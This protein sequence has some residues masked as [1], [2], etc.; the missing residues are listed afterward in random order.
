[1]RRIRIG[2]IG[3]QNRGVRAHAAIPKALQAAG[4]A[5]NA[6]VEPVWLPTAH[7]AEGTEAKLSGLDGLW[8]VPNSPY[9]STQGALQ[10]IRH[11]RER[12]RPFLGTCGGFQHTL[13]EYA[14]HVIGMEYADHCETNPAAAVPLLHR[15]ACSLVGVRGTIRI[16]PGSRAREMYGSESVIEEYHCNYGLNE[17]YR[18]R[19]ADGKLRV[20]GEDEAGN[21]RI[22]EL[23]GHPFFVATLFQP[24]LSAL[25]AA[26]PHPIVLEFVRAA[27]LAESA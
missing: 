9:E 2:L 8:C 21:V 14:R 26:I 5:L 20:T 6:G 16:L 1:M 27:T 18:S 24:E 17:V 23:T 4:S 7:L 12:G 11:A 25:Y 15:L 22:V 13:L 10:A 3:E 19:L